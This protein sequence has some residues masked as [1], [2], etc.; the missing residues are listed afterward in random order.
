[1]R[2]L[3]IAV[4]LALIVSLLFSIFFPG[5]IRAWLGIPISSMRKVSNH[6]WD[7]M[8]H[9]MGYGMLGALVYGLVREIRRYQNYHP[10]AWKFSTAL[11]AVGAVDELLQNPHIRKV[12][13][14]G[15]LD[16][17]P[18][19]SSFSDFLADLTGIML[20]STMAWKFFSRLD[21][22]KHPQEVETDPKN[23]MDASGDETA[24]SSDSVSDSP[25]ISE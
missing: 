17:I 18:R 22:R 21:S 23:Q 16:P 11:L 2:S 19:C 14:F 3:R 24:S 20:F 25:A 5:T 1:M 15:M 12:V 10:L 9:C 4:Y 7:W 8:V 13:S 6:P